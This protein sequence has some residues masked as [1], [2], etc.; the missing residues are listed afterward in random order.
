MLRMNRKFLDIPTLIK[1]RF[2]SMIGIIVHEK[3]R[4]GAKKQIVESL[5]FEPAYRISDA[6]QSFR[7]LRACERA[8]YNLS[9]QSESLTEHLYDKSQTEQNSFAIRV[10]D[11]SRYGVRPINLSED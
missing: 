6:S 5:I 1:V 9:K 11:V 3:E 8:P 4:S 7:L 10:A 2:V